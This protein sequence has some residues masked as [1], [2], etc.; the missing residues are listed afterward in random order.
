MIKIDDLVNNYRS[1]SLK[2]HNTFNF[3]DKKKYIDKNSSIIKKVFAKGLEDEFFNVLYLD[4]EPFILADIALDSFNFK[5]NLYKSRDTMLYLKN[6]AYSLRFSENLEINENAQKY[7]ANYDIMKF[8][9]EIKFFNEINDLYLYNQYYKYLDLITIYYKCYINNSNVDN[10]NNSI[11]NLLL[12][13]R[14]NDKIDNFF[15]I[16]TNNY[17]KTGQYIYISLNYYYIWKTKGNSQGVLKKME[18][19]LSKNLTNTP[20]LSALIFQ[21]IN[22]IKNINIRQ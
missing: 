1:N 19:L 4:K 8:E 18:D 11:Y 17:E 3:S 20:Q 14:S 9:N 5:Y 2:L 6:N 15:E 13:I 7:Y 21:F 22:E 12:D 10:I 16:T